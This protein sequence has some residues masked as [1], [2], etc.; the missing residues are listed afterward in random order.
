MFVNFSV[1]V[2]KDSLYVEHTK[3]K[4]ISVR[5]KKLKDDYLLL[6]LVPVFLSG[7][8]TIGVQQ[9]YPQI[10]IVELSILLET[11]RHCCIIVQIPGSPVCKSVQ[12]SPTIRTKLYFLLLYM[13][14][15]FGFSQQ[16]LYSQNPNL[17]TFVFFFLSL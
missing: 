5:F 2:Y 1:F 12:E 17:Q 14:T 4:F 10:V 13:Q 6:P 9:S 3:N 16:V 15:S 7:Q 8:Q 11:S